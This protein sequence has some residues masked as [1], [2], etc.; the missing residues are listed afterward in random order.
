[1]KKKMIAG[2]TTLAIGV[3]V[4]IVGVVFLVVRLVAG[5]GVPDGEYLVSAKEWTLEGAEGVVWDFTEVGK[6]K[7]TT[8][9]HVNDYDFI[10]SLEDGRLLIETDWLYELENAYDY[11]L[12]R[13]AGVLTLTEGEKEIK[14]VGDFTDNQ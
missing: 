6:G 7:L 13:G 11:K 2:I 14:F 10:W 8:N 5:P 3:V 1:M 4:L 12:D 9:N